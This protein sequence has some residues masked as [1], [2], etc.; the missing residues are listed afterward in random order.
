[1]VKKKLRKRKSFDDKD[2]Q[3]LSDIENKE[4]IEY[5]QYYN[6]E[7]NNNET[8]NGS[9]EMINKKNLNKTTEDSNEMKKL[10][11]S[12]VNDINFLK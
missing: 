2:V 10:L 9:K 11:S 12:T 5:K 3:L 7:N 4:N 1:M 8:N 6:V